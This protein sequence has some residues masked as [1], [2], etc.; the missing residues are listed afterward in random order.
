MNLVEHAL[1]GAAAFAAGGVNAL[2]GGGTL[3]S[4]PVLV[5]LGVPPVAANVTNTVALSPGYLGGAIAQRT[6]ISAQRDRVRRLGL[7]AAIGG[8]LGSILLVLTS[9]RRL[10]GPHPRAPVPGDAAPGHPG[11]DPQ[12]PEDRRARRGASPTTARRRPCPPTPPG[13]RSR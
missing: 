1:A 12:G 3:I 8:L 6:A 5:A 2:A 11:P 4:F 9:G 7:S 13:S 10:P